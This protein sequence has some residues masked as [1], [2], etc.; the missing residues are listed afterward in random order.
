VVDGEL[1]AALRDLERMLAGGQGPVRLGK[2]GELVIGPLTAEGIPAEA[3]E[4]KDELAGLIPFAPIASVLVELDR[5]TGFLD[6]F[7]HAGGAKPRSRELKRNLIAVLIAN[8]TNMGLA[9]CRP[10]RASPT[11]PSPGPRNGTCGKKRCGRRT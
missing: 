6:C 8:A 11:T 4:L 2:N 3:A 1:R 10:P 9:P 7:T 5:Q